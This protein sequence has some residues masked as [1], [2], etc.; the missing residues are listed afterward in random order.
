MIKTKS[1]ASYPWICP[2]CGVECLT[3]LSTTKTKCYNGHHVKL[4]V[5]EEIKTK[6]VARVTKGFL[7]IISSTRL[8]RTATLSKGE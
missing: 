8:L 3:E 6:H 1:D 2:E 7:G 4:G 5:V